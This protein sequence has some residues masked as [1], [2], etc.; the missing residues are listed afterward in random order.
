MRLPSS[1]LTQSVILWSLS[2]LFL[3]HVSKSTRMMPKLV[4]E[5]GAEDHRRIRMR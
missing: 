1:L 4:R 2:S 3:A 5:E